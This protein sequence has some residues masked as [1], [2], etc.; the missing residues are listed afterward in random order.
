MKKSVMLI[1]SEKPKAQPPVAG[2]ATC[3]ASPEEW[4]TKYASLL[5]QKMELGGVQSFL[6]EKMPNGKFEFEVTPTGWPNSFYVREENKKTEE[7][8][9]IRAD[10][11]RSLRAM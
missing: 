11:A 10:R 1:A 5:A 4:W 8:G 2:S 3:S 7:N 9:K 6:I